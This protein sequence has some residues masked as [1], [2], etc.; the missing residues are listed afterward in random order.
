MD[1]AGW[2]WMRNNRD[3]GHRMW[4]SEDCLAASKEYGKEGVYA[5]KGDDSVIWVGKVK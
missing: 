5:T 1:Q 4:G 2:C 3:Y